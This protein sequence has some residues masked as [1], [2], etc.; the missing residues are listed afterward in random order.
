[1]NDLKNKLEMFCRLSGVNIEDV[2]KLFAE[3]VKQVEKEKRWLTIKQTAKLYGV[4]Y[5]TIYRQI[6][7][8][9][10]KYKRIRRKILVEVDF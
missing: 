6:Q 4:C 3:D 2:K 5:M 1:M 10:I 8:N 7:E 9:K